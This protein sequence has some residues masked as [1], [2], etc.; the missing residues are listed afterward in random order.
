MNRMLSVGVVLSVVAALVLV[1]TAAVA[2]SGEGKKVFDF[3]SMV[4]VSGAFLGSTMPLRGVN[5]GG[6]PWVIG[7]ARATLRMNGAFEVEVEGLVLDPANETAQA[8]GIAGKNPVPFFFA[9]ISCLDNTGAVVNTDTATVHATISGD[10]EI[11]Q[12][13][14]LPTSCFAPIVLVRGSGTGNPVGPWFAASGF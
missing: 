10:A 5:G 11:E 9:T 7:E 2:S 8:R 3:R 6:L 14:S 13:V 12:V 1:G 4:G